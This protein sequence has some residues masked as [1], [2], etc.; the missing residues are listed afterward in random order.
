M[1]TSDPS[2]QAL[3]STVS[4]LELHAEH[5][6]SKLAARDAQIARELIEKPAIAE[7]TQLQG[8]AEAVND[9]CG[10]ARQAFRVVDGELEPKS[11]IGTRSVQ[12]FVRELQTSAPHLFGQTRETQSPAAKLHSGSNPWRKATFNLTRQGEI[13]RTNQQLAERL[14]VEAGR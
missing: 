13:V 5:L 4:S 7:F 11:I 1:T 3:E 8:R 14:Q 10:R 9:V 2:I 12:T 6:K